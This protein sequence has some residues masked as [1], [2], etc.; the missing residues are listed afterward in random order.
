MYIYWM[1]SIM[2][3]CDR[4]R[5]QFKWYDPCVWGNIIVTHECHPL[6]IA[7][8]TL[9]HF[10]CMVGCVL[11]VCDPLNC[12]L[13]RVAVDLQPVF[14]AFVTIAGTFCTAY[15]GVTSIFRG[16][17]VR[18][19]LGLLVE[20]L[21]LLGG[22]GSWHLILTM[23]IMSVDVSFWL[24]VYAIK[25][26]SYFFTDVTLLIIFCEHKRCQTRKDIMSSDDGVGGDKMQVCHNP[27]LMLATKMLMP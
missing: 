21:V 16:D 9:F 27:R 4:C 13:Q 22:Q 10:A 23:C 3:G 18:F 14:I 8:D 20:K 11:W 15:A 26:V 17:S 2:S 7:L 6:Y 5:H 25:S 12:E 19:P 24:C 1:P